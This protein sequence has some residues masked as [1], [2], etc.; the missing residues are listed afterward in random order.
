MTEK[1]CTSGEKKNGKN[2]RIFPSFFKIV[3]F[4]VQPVKLIGTS[5]QKWLNNE[6]IGVQLFIN[7][8]QMN[9]M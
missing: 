3:I 6:T 5:C 4:S 1:H 9:A 8:M 2:L 7:L